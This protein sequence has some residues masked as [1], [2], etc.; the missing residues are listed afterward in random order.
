MYSLEGIYGQ[1]D[2]I[3]Y[4]ELDMELG[5]LEEFMKDLLALANI[6]TFLMS[7]TWLWL[8]N[9]GIM[10]QESMVLEYKTCWLL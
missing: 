4:M 7:Q 9:L 2:L 6:I 5:I 1:K 3:I 8:I 10:K